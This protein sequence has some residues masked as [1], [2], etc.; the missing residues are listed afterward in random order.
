[1]GAT[2][3]LASTGSTIGC[4]EA[5]ATE[6]RQFACDKGQGYLFSKP[7]LPADLVQWLSAER[8]D[9]C[10]FIVTLAGELHAAR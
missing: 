6:V 4:T 2:A 1:L 10:R 8:P 3:A 5:Q 9:G 7:L